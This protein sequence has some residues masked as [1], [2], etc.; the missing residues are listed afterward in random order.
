MLPGTFRRQFF[1]DDEKRMLPSARVAPCNEVLD[2]VLSSMTI[3]EFGIF[4]SITYRHN[5]II[6]FIH[7]QPTLTG[8]PTDVGV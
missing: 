2:P 3:I 1:E 4:L 8:F 5:F 7:Y 6:R